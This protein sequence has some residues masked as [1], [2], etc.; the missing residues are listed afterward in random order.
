[1]ERSEKEGDSVFTRAFLDALKGGSRTNADREFLILDEVVADLKIRVGRFTGAGSGR[2]MTPK[3]WPIPRDEAKDTGTFVFLNPG[4]KRRPAPDLIERILAVIPKQS[5]QAQVRD[6]LIVQVYQRS[7]S[8]GQFVVGA[9]VTLNVMLESLTSEAKVDDDGHARFKLQNPGPVALKVTVNRQN[10]LRTAALPGVN[11]PYLPYVIPVD[12]AIIPSDGWVAAGEVTPQVLSVGSG[13]HAAIVTPSRGVILGNERYA[14]E[15][16]PWGVPDAEVAIHRVGYSLGYDPK[17]RI[18]R[19]VSYR[20]AA[21]SQ[22]L[23]KASRGEQRFLPDPLLEA[24]SFAEPKLSLKPI[25]R[26]ELADYTRS[27]Y[28]RGNL[29]SIVDMVFRGDRARAEASYLSTMVP[30]TP[31]CNQITWRL[32]E[33]YTREFAEKGDDLIVTA[34]PA[35]IPQVAGKPI[36]YFTIGKN[37]VAVPTHLF[38]V[39][40]RRRDDGPPET[41]TFLV[42]NDGAVRKDIQALL[43]SLADVERY[44]GLTLFP[45]MQPAVKVALRGPAATQLWR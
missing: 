42:P 40:A 27:G 23:L 13:S 32:I 20:L 16:A 3:L 9:N 29:V 7:P 19:W 31:I 12:I 21:P 17:D 25:P 8:P 14:A 36:R 24:A 22:E 39:I 10:R 34:G 45:K 15:N 28:D 11:V 38:R 41:L 18:P 5:D 37:K 35:F 43:V 26:A 44:T 1:M 6:D 4:A 33:T 30:Q 2:K